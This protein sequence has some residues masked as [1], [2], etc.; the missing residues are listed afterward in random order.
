MVLSSHRDHHTTPHHPWALVFSVQK[1]AEEEK[2]ALT[3]SRL[4][5]GFRVPVD[6]EEPSPGLYGGQLTSFLPWLN[7][8]YPLATLLLFKK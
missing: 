5:S 6:R 1:T 4:S 8:S 3:R 7:E 2:Q